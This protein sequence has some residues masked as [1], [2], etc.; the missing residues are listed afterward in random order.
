MYTAYRLYEG[1]VLMI[2]PS[3]IP[4]YSLRRL[5]HAAAARSDAMPAASMPEP[6]RSPVF[7]GAAVIVPAAVVAAAVVAAVVVV[8]VV[9]ADS[10]EVVLSPD[11]VSVE[12]AVSVSAAEVSVTV[13]VVSGSALSA[14]AE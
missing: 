11:A 1:G 9:T 4:L 2:N 3:E 5:V 7:G 14:E 10:S 12:A 6:A 8:T 13:V